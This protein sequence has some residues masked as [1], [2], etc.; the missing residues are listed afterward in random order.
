MTLTLFLSITVL[1]FQRISKYI[2]PTA[3]TSTFLSYLLS[4]SFEIGI[5]VNMLQHNFEHYKHVN[6]P[7]ATVKVFSPAQ[8]PCTVWFLYQLFSQLSS[9]HLDG[10]QWPDQ[11]L[12]SL[13]YL[14]ETW[15]WQAKR[16]HEI[17]W[18]TPWVRRVDQWFHSFMLTF[19]SLWMRFL[20]W[21][22]ATPLTICWARARP[23]T[24]LLSS[25]SKPFLSSIQFLSVFSHNSIWM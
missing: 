2:K 17:K 24:L 9:L 21:M 11:S 15:C 1:R 7:A 16:G 3:N 22:Y 5:K 8:E 4:N 18:P 10:P 20:E 13:F 19:R 14:P 6:V 12:R 25:V 23:S